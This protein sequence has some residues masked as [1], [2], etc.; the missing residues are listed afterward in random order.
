MD[1]VVLTCIL[2]SSV[3]VA[4]VTAIKELVIWKLNRKAKIDDRKVEEEDTLTNLSTQ[5]DTHQKSIDELVSILNNLETKMDVSSNGMRVILKDRIKYIA[6]GYIHREKISLED[7]K[8]LKEMWQI[9]HF[10][11]KGNGDLDD[12]MSLV[13]ELPLDI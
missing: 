4:L 12:I 3:A 5:I 10:D 6:L 7:K 2:S 11:L 13:E 1:Q 9:Y 8:N